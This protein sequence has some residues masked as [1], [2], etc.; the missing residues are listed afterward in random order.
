M[1]KNLLF[2]SP[3]VDFCS[4]FVLFGFLEEFEL[5][6]VPFIMRDGAVEQK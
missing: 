5:K 2:V 4:F 6:L 1:K 3:P